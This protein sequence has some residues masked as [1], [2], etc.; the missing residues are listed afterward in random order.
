MPTE[1]SGAWSAGLLWHDAAVHA[2]GWLE[3]PGEDFAV[4]ASL[5]VALPTGK[6]T[7]RLD[8]S[9]AIDFAAERN[10]L[11]KVLAAARRELEPCE[12]KL[13]NPKFVGRVSADVVATTRAARTLPSPTSTG[14]MPS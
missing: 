14:S 9:E 4:T 1:L 5:E 13:G 11:I 7:V 2:I 6:V 12:G 10:R 8:I 3:E